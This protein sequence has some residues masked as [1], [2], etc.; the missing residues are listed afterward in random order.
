MEIISRL[1]LSERALFQIF[2]WFGRILRDSFLDLAREVR[3]RAVVAIA[4]LVGGWFLS[5]IANIYELNRRPTATEFLWLLIAEAPKD[6]VLWVL[7]GA[8]I[9]IDLAIIYPLYSVGCIILVSGYIILFVLIQ[10][11]RRLI[12]EQADLLREADDDR[13]LLSLAGLSEWWPHTRPDGSGVSSGVSWEELRAE[14]QRSENNTLHI[15]A[16]NGLETFGAP[17]APLYHALQQFRGTVQILLVDPAS[18]QID[19]R[20]RALGISKYRYRRAI[21]IS[22]RRLRELRK[23]H[24]LVEGRYYEAQPNW[25]LILTNR[26]AWVQYYAPGGPHVNEAAC[27]R[28]DA[29]EKGTGLYHLFFL[30]FE[31]IW[32]SC[33]LN[34]MDL[35]PI[36]G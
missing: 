27:W 24:R 5:V 22:E 12:D 18:E 10:R 15:L 31:R 6:F 2:K 26:R 7:R 11:A 34:Q 14:I 23:Q 1:D 3:K 13:E 20:A 4:I 33:E 29:T 9:V 32:R 25:K 28:F 36:F 17:E 19:G 30:E 21:R 16:A 35:G 8:R